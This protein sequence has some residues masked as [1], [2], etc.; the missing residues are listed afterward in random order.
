MVRVTQILYGLS[1]VPTALPALWQISGLFI[2]LTLCSNVLAAV[3]SVGRHRKHLL[4]TELRSYR[5]VLVRYEAASLYNW[6]P[7]YQHGVVIFR[8]SRFAGR[9]SGT[10]GMYVDGATSNRMCPLL[11][12]YVMTHQP[13]FVHPSWTFRQDHCSASKRREPI[14]E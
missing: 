4:K 14:T 9:M 6:F 10:V 2:R 13:L 3:R 8:G 11:H 7:T 12:P 5:G 1:R